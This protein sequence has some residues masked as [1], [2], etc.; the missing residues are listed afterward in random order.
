MK[1]RLT[2]ND[3][4]LLWLAFKKTCAICGHALDFFDME[5][6]HVVPFR[7][8]GRTN[9]FEMQAVH[10]RCNREKGARCP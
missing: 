7:D 2:R 10:R 3:R 1:R 5:A 8:T 4:Y 9:Y 6:D